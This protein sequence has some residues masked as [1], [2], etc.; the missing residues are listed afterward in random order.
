MDLNRRLARR[1][2]VDKVLLMPSGTSF[3]CADLAYEQLDKIMNP[4]LSKQ[5]FL[6]AKQRE[7]ERRR[8]K[9]AK[10]K[11]LDQ[12]DEDELEDN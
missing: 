12:D 2:I 8:R 9:K 4:G 3:Y 11:A 7:R 1:L 10:K 6:R 5:E